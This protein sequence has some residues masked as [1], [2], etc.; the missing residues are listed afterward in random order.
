MKD[1]ESQ[2]EFAESAYDELVTASAKLA[3]LVAEHSKTDYSHDNSPFE[4][5]EIGYRDGE[6][7]EL[8]T[9]GFDTSYFECSNGLDLI[10]YTHT[11]LSNTEE[12]LY[13]ISPATLPEEYFNRELIHSH[14]KLYQ[15]LEQIQSFLEDSGIT[16]QAMEIVE[17]NSED[18][19]RHHSR[20]EFE[21]PEN[22]Q[23]EIKQRNTQ[24]ESAN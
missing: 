12:A 5:E 13:R 15:D 21:I 4:L 14:Q 20:A 3:N 17:S 11:L 18:Y 10:E 16:Q 19:R 8:L 22:I 23:S 1:L 2:L 6:V 9:T 24:K 7:E